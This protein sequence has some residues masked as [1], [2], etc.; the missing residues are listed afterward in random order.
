MKDWKDVYNY[1]K[2][3]ERSLEGN[4]EA[5]TTCIDNEYMANKDNPEYQIAYKKWCDEE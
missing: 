2:D 1:F 4:G 3:I 5:I